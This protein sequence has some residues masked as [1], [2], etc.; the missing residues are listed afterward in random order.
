MEAGLYIVAT[1]IGNARDIT[2]RALDVLARADVI[3]CEDSR[4]SGRFLS[5]YGI[6]ARLTVYHDHNAQRVRPGL[7]RRLKM[8]EIVALISDA[9]TPLI[10]DP[11]FKLVAAARDEGIDV[12]AVPGASAVLAALSVAGLPTDRFLFAGFAPSKAAARIKFLRQF[13]TLDAS[14][15]FYESARRLAASLDAMA[16]LYGPREAVVARELTK[17]HEEIRRASLVE[18]ARHYGEHG[19]PKGEV[20]V[21]VAPP[22][23]ALPV[24]DDDALE[25]A[26]EIAL[27]AQPLRAAVDA[28][29]ELSGRRRR[30][31]YA[32]ALA[33]RKRT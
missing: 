18:L 22:G 17:L 10:S 21:I 19:A 6:K 8:G 11:G 23:E 15:V 14:L 4:V 3:A 31:V 1:P 32:M 16:A 27:E 26:L 2:F 29:S 33:M 12:F 30:E 20:V 13:A 5:R 7:I 25:A 9:G 24:F 28:V